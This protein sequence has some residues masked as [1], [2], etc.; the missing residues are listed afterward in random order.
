MAV[1]TKTEKKAKL[2]FVGFLWVGPI[3][4]MKC[5]QRTNMKEKRE[6]QELTGTEEQ[7]LKKGAEIPQKLTRKTTELSE[8][9][10]VT[11]LMCSCARTV[12]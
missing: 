3:D 2:I 10:P 4:L 6:E 1:I 12:L 11:K 7:E 9:I 5:F 8:L